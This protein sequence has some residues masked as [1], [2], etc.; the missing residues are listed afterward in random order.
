[1][2]DVVRCFCERWPWGV[3]TARRIGGLVE[4]LHGLLMRRGSAHFHTE[5]N[6][7]LLLLLAL[8]RSVS[9]VAGLIEVVAGSRCP[10]LPP[11]KGFLPYGDSS[12]ESANGEASILL[13]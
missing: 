6:T 3:L 5:G 2:L 8:E 1:M 10:P 7:A 13:S 4:Q 11:P 12:G 9:V